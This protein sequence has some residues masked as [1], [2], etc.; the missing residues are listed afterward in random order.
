MCG[1]AMPEVN[2]PAISPDDAPAANMPSCRST[3]SRSVP[4]SP[5]TSSA[6]PT[7]SSPCLAAA[8]CSDLGMVPASSHSCRC[9]TTSRRVNSAATS[10]MSVM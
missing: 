7:P 9:G 10:R 4:P 8:A 3:V 5:P 1:S 6:N 2:S